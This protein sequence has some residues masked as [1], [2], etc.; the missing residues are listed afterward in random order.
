MSDQ[1]PPLNDSLPMQLLRAR[2]VI[3]RRLRT[4]Y[5]GRDLTEQQWRVL[6]VLV[7]VASIDM[8]RLA[9]GAFIHAPSLSRIIPKLEVRGLIRRTPSTVDRRQTFVELTEA[10][11]AL[12]ESIRPAVAAGFAQLQ[13]G[14]GHERVR[15]FQE[16]LV[17]LIQD[18]G[19]LATP[20][21]EAA[22]AEGLLEEIV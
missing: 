22:S 2:E 8:Q 4:T 13:A 9:E 14:L 17:R 16:E 19:L 15:Q 11:R 20:G 18:A 5:A 10:G 12:F 3:M 21:D 1:L 7:E 6:R